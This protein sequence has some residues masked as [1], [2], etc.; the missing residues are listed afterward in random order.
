MTYFGLKFDHFV[1]IIFFFKNCPKMF[2]EQIKSVLIPSMV[3]VGPVEASIKKNKFKNAIFLKFEKNV[4]S[5]KSYFSIFF[6]E[7][8][9]GPTTT[10]R[11]SKRF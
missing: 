3:V 10:M 4:T 7:A 9:T 2:S 5:Q 6:V 1:K 8:S 11:V